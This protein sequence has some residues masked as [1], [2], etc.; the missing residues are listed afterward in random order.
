ML[1]MEF[2]ESLHVVSMIRYQAEP[3]FRN[4][5]NDLY[6]T[7]LEAKSKKDVVLT[8]LCKSLM[9]EA[10][11]KFAQIAMPLIAT[12]DSQEMLQMLDELEVYNP[13][14]VSHIP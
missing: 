9:N 2:L 1:K 7:R 3:L 10:Y 13:E 4:F 5:I 12:G 14:E 11:G 6:T 8:Q